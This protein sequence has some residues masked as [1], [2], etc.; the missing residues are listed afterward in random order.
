MFSMVVAMDSER[1]IGK[2]GSIPWKLEGEMR[3]FRELTS[4]PE[5]LLIHAR[6]R[7]DAGLRD[8][9]TF[10]TWRRTT[11]WGRL[12]TR[13]RKVGALGRPATQV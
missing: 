11:P 9:R 8:K 1:G 3:F 2:A 7:L 13:Y 10:Q 6:Y 5:V 4:C 12:F